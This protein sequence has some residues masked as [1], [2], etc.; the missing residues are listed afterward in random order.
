MQT[1]LVME[2]LREYFLVWNLW[3]ELSFFLCEMESGSAN[4]ESK[5]L[6]GDSKG[7]EFV[8]VFLI[9]ETKRTVPLLPTITIILASF[10][11]LKVFS[12]LENCAMKEC[13]A[14]SLSST[15]AKIP[16]TLSSPSTTPKIEFSKKDCLEEDMWEGLLSE[17][18]KQFPLFVPTKTLL[19]FE[20]QLSSPKIAEKKRELRYV[21]EAKLWEWL[22]LVFGERVGERNSLMNE[23]LKE[24][25]NA[26]HIF[27]YLNNPKPNS[28]I[29]QI[30]LSPLFSPFSFFTNSPLSF[31]ADLLNNSPFSLIGD[32][33]RKILF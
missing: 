30:K 11:W 23:K 26:L 10:F 7:V 32:W 1:Q 9:K 3:R 6:R 19:S 4:F 17:T 14:L 21:V 15:D 33:S 25:S 27:S 24:L 16:T 13:V 8:R 12:F 29:L 31:Q 5:D 2:K 20:M 28:A 22:S 18:Q